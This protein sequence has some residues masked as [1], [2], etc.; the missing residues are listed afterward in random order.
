MLPALFFLLV[1]GGV[2]GWVYYRREFRVRARPLLLAARI[3]VVAGV[4]ALIWNPVVSTAPADSSP[5]R[6]VI[7]DASAS[8]SAVAPD[9]A[10]LWDSAVARAR[11]RAEGGARLLLAGATVMAVDPD[12]LDT[13]SPSAVRSVFGEAVAVAAEA[14]AREITLI[15]D[16]RVSDPVAVTRTARRLGVGVSVNRLHEPGANLGLARLVLPPTAESGAQIRGRVDVQGTSGADSVTVTVRVDG[17]ASHTLRLA[18]P[19][20]GGLGTAE[21]SLDG[22]AAGSHRVTARLETQDAFPLDDERTAV[23]EV[24]P[25]E[26]GVLLVSFGPDWEP[27]FLL[28]VLD[29][30]TGLPVRGYLRAGTDNFQPM[31]ATGV[32]EAVDQAGL[33]RLLRRAEMVVAMGV[34]GASLQFLE[35]ATART[36]GLIVFPAD[37]AGAALAGVAAG[38]P[39]PG[40]W[41][42]HEAPPSPIAGE[43]GRLLDLPPLSAVLPLVDDGGG[44]ALSVRL[45]GAGEPEAALV[46]RDEGSRRV[47][48]VL[49]RGFWRWAFRDGVPREHYRRLW[50]AVGGWILSE[51][52]GA[53]GPGV[54]PAEPVLGPGTPVRWRG[55]GYE[56]EEISLSI[57]DSASA[58]TLDTVTVVPPGALFTTPPLPP[59]RYEYTVAASDTAAGAFEVEPF[60]E[61][62]L[63][64]ALDPAELTVPAGE[65]GPSARSGRPLRTWP[66][67]Y[68]LVIGLLCA[69]WIGRRRAGLR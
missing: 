35:R 31:M 47:A 45:G 8:M 3:G 7:L 46:L 6:F 26:T 61:E 11:Q 44:E 58:P 19:E 67:P 10:P 57:T 49:A 23:V 36:R 12:S 27:R 29:Q 52:P 50:A 48:A 41:Y 28:T 65:R 18:A 63:R 60:T 51:G 21:F 5:A 1:A 39:L 40:E 64:R 16:R 33:E 53:G 13:V 15:T 34:D 56:G 37:G 2:C 4:T 38:A 55:R 14:G 42:L 54:R 17:R 30:V 59:G 69:E 66:W 20:Q 32:A 43:T 62:M 25:E 9:G 68:L 22:L 24:D